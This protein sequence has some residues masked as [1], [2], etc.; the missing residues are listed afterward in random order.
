MWAQ[1][2]R[3]I[4]H[5]VYR[6]LWFQIQYV[7]CVPHAHDVQISYYRVWPGICTTTTRQKKHIQ[8]W[9]FVWSLLKNVHVTN[10]GLSK[11]FWYPLHQL[12]C[13][14]PLV[15]A[16][17]VLFPKFPTFTAANDTCARSNDNKLLIICSNSA[18]TRAC[19]W[20]YMFYTFNMQT[21]E[22][23]KTKQIIRTN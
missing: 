6:F 15:F 16:T 22:E 4:S 14:T 13:P 10:G 8:T 12:R 23:N 3:S 11:L 17:F 2:E 21:S 1:N 5:V 20:S 18:T 9:D 19:I 7:A